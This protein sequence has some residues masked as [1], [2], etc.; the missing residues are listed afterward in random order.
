MQ[1]TTKSGLTLQLP[2]LEEDAQ[3]SAAL[4]EESPELEESFFQ[5]AVPAKDILGSDMVSWLNGKAPTPENTPPTGAHG[6]LTDSV[7]PAPT[8]GTALS[9]YCASGWQRID[10]MPQPTLMTLENLEPMSSGR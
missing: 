10:A 1:I 4:D 3:I 8:G 2:S 9:T 7:P 5:R 6:P